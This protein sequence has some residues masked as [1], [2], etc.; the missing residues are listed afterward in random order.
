MS[1]SD[2]WKNELQGLSLCE[3]LAEY[4]ENN[5]D[6]ATDLSP[7]WEGENVNLQSCIPLRLYGDGADV[8]GSFAD[9]IEFEHI[10]LAR[11]LECQ[12]RG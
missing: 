7:F 6:L 3:A 1:F 2:P 8:L 9:L 11:S 4:W 5:R 12:V 10:C